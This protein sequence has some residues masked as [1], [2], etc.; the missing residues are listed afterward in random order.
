[1]TEANTTALE[2]E[3]KSLRRKAD[4]YDYAFNLGFR[5]GFAYL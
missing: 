5:Q 1:L 3:I 4:N 2:K